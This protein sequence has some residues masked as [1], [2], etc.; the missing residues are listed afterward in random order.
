M[1]KCSIIIASYNEATHLENC[2][3]SLRRLDY[4]IDS[5][6]VLLVDNNSTDNT[7]EVASK[8]PEVTYLK[9]PSRGPSNARNRGIEHAKYDIL[10]FLDADSVVSPEWLSELLKPFTDTDV[11]A[12]GGEIRPLAQDN[13]IS[14]YLSISLLM[15]YHRWGGKREINAFPSCN[16]AVRKKAISGG[17]DPEHLRG[18]DKELCYRILNKGYKIVFQPG[19]VI[20]H[21]HPGTLKALTELFIKGALGRA[22]LGKA[23]RNKIDILIF[24]FHVPLVYFIILVFLIFSGNLMLGTVLLCIPIVY[25]A[26]SSIIAARVSGKIFLSLVVKPVLD[27]YS[28]LVTY[29]AYQ[30]FIITGKTGP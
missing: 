3:D 28:I 16:L 29:I 23:Y 10:V 7:P 19:A 8:F 26:A 6:E 12:V 15:R 2:L 27:V 11:G 1:E 17:F 14:E 20:Y 13:T 5:F 30:Y 22:S 18:Q 25:I 9:E 4:P 21:A 24:K